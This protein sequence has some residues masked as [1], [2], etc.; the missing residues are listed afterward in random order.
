M[1]EKNFKDGLKKLYYRE[2]KIAP[3]IIAWAKAG[4]K[5]ACV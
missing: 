1:R 3:S 2:N 4:V 5:Y